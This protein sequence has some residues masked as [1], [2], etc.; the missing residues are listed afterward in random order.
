MIYGALIVKNPWLERDP[1][2][3]PSK[4]RLNKTIHPKKKS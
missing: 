3:K 2:G 4:S 1:R